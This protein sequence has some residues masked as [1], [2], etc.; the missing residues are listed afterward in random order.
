MGSRCRRCARSAVI[1]TQM[2]PLVWRIMK[3]IFSG[4]AAPAAMMRSPSFS[5]SVSSTTITSCPWRMAAMASL[6]VSS[7]M[8]V[9]VWPL[10]RVFLAAKPAAI[11]GFS[12]AVSLEEGGQ[13]V[14]VHACFLRDA[15]GK[16]D[17]GRAE[18]ALRPIQPVGNGI[19]DGPVVNRQQPA[20]LDRR[21]RQGRPGQR[22]AQ[23]AGGGI[24]HQIV[25][26]EP[27]VLR[28]GP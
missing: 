15:L 27:A 22:N 10:R 4:V 11:K 13:G 19:E 16:G 6:T 24:Q 25:V 12:R 28:T 20:G 2:M 14:G 21:L 17:G 5:R 18:G 9:P 8:M 26:L 1:G 23:A 3:A 7:F